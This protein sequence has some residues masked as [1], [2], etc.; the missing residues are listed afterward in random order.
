MVCEFLALVF[1]YVIGICYILMCTKVD[2]K[3]YYNG[4][5]KKVKQIVLDLA[6]KES[7]VNSRRLI[8]NFI[9]QFYKPLTFLCI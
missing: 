5:V 4:K 8:K 1:C 6:E 3:R 2:N 9:M 7:G